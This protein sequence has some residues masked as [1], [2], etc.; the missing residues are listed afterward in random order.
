MIVRHT[1]EAIRL[2]DILI[3]V[4]KKRYKDIVSRVEDNRVIFNFGSEEAS[5]TGQTDIREYLDCHDIPGRVIEYRRTVILI[6]PR[7]A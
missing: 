2:R 4:L 1:E 3:P 5:I 7:S 6:L